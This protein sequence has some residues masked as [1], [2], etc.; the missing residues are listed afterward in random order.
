MS[1]SRE[2]D[3]YSCVDLLTARQFS[4]ALHI[5]IFCR[6]EICGLIDNVLAGGLSRRL[7]GYLISFPDCALPGGGVRSDRLRSGRA[8]STGGDSAQQWF[9]D[10]IIQVARPLTEAHAR[11]RS[12]FHTLN[13]LRHSR[14]A[15][16]SRRCR[17][18]A[19]GSKRRECGRPCRA[20][21]GSGSGSSGAVR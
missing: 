16:R 11:R 8:G 21:S 19:S 1:A 5:G 2:K 13:Q 3:I 17:S 4:S 12:A 18:P 7:A 6:S 20:G 15:A 9:R 10:L 14:S